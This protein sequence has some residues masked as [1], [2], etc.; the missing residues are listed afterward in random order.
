MHKN[1]MIKD[2]LNSRN[3]IIL[4]EEAK[5]DINNCNNSPFSQAQTSFSFRESKKP[6]EI[7]ISEFPEVIEP[8]PL[9]N[10]PSFNLYNPKEKMNSNN[11]NSCFNLIKI[12]LNKNI[13]N[14]NNNSFIGKKRKIENEELLFINNKNE[15]NLNMNQSAFKKLENNNQNMLGLYNSKSAFRPNISYHK[16][17]TVNKNK[18]IKN[19]KNKIIINEINNES[20]NKIPIKKTIFKSINISNINEGE[21]IINE[22]NLEKRR[23]GRKPKMQE[24]KKKVHDAYDYDNILRKIQ[25]HFLTFI[26][27]FC[28]DLIEAFLPNNKEL[29]FKNLNYQLKKTVNHSYVENLKA[30]KVGDILQFEVSS[31]IRKFHNTINQQIYH[32]V[33]QL[34]PILNNFFNLSYLEL[35]NQYYFKSKTVIYVEGKKINISE[36]TKFFSD[37]IDKNI[38]GAQKIQEIAIHNFIESKNDNKQTIFVINKKKL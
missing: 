9:F 19:I 28:N 21:N 15:D 35:F 32:K 31:K 4:L 14:N 16:L 8:K 13:P 2:N 10:F 23:R 3:N 22:N 7:N 30:K 25:V 37:L 36:R 33:C 20:I 29:K 1:K 24:T 6:E 27:C 17:K 26:I 18:K 5:K 34:S 11:F 12:N 38:E